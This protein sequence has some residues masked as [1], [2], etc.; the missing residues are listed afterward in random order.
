MNNK[1]YNII[2]KNDAKK[3]DYPYYNLTYKL[4]KKHIKELVKNFIPYILDRPP[5][6]FNLEKFNGS[7]FII[8]DIWNNNIEINYLTDYF[9]EKARVKCIFGNYLA[10]YDYWQKNKDYIKRKYCIKVFI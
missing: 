5:N 4:D 3:I 10:P 6:G 1:N 7:Y 2:S 9:S 8:W